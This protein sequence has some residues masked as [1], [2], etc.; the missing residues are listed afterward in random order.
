MALRSDL[1]SAMPTASRES[2]EAAGI[3]GTYLDADTPL[4][5]ELAAGIVD[6]SIRGAY[7][8]GS[9]GT[10]K[11]HAACAVAQRLCAWGWRPLVTTATAMMGEVRASYDGAG[12]P[13]EAFCSARML[14]LDDADKLRMTDWELET[15]YAVVDAR[16]VGRLATVVTANRDPQGLRA[17][18]ADRSPAYADAIYDRIRDGCRA[19]EMSGRSR[20]EW[21]R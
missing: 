16:C 5:R 3:R 6:G 1:L 21:A 7:L 19:V 17:Q 4:A 15:L 11:T 13:L 10:G 12:T 14:V 20:R 9:N 18:M 8:Y 2:Q